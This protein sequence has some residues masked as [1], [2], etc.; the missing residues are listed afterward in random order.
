MDRIEI[1]AMVDTMALHINAVC[2]NDR[3]V[4]DKII[5]RLFIESLS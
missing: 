1:L 2:C 5:I 3:F 4:T